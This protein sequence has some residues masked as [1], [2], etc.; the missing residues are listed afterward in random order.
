[1]VGVTQVTVDGGPGGTGSVTRCEE[2]IARNA[3][4]RASGHL[5][6][7]VLD[8]HH[9]DLLR[10]VEDKELARRRARLA[11][12]LAASTG[13]GW[14]RGDPHQMA[15]MINRMSGREATT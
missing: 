3:W 1:L 14:I 9:A 12:I 15:A 2:H 13:C 8:D 6:D 11:R 4:Y 5:L 10:L 7:K